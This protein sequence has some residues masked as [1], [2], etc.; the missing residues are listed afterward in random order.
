MRELAVQRTHTRAIQPDFRAR[1]V[2]LLIGNPRE[3]RRELRRLL[4]EKSEVVARAHEVADRRRN[5]VAL[6]VGRGDDA[7]LRI[8]RHERFTRARR[9]HFRRTP[10]GRNLENRAGLR[11]AFAARFHAAAI[12]DAALRDICRTIGPH[13]HVEREGPRRLALNHLVVEILEPVGLTVAVSIVK[14]HDAVFRRD[15]NHAAG[16]R[17]RER[18]LQARGKAPPFQACQ[19]LIRDAVQQPHVAVIRDNRRA[20]RREKRDVGHAHAA[21]PRVHF[22]RRN[23]VN[24]ETVLRHRAEGH[25]RGEHTGPA[26]TRRSHGPRR[27]GR[28]DRRR[29]RGG[30]E[31]DA[32]AHALGQGRRGER[33]HEFALIVAQYQRLA[34]GDDAGA[35]RI[36]FER[37]AHGPRRTARRADGDDQRRGVGRHFQI[38]QNLGLRP[39]HARLQPLADF[40]V[41]IAVAQHRGV[42]REFHALEMRATRRQCAAAN[43]ARTHRRPRIRVQRPD[44]HADSRMHGRAQ[45]RR[46][47]RLRVRRVGFSP[48]VG[49][50]DLR[51]AHERDGRLARGHFPDRRDAQQLLVKNHGVTRRERQHDAAHHKIP[52]T[53]R[54]FPLRHHFQLRLEKRLLLF[55]KRTGLGHCRR[56]GKTVWC[57]GQRNPKKEPR[58]KC[59]DGRKMFLCAEIARSQDENGAKK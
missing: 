1:G 19:F 30:V 15:L 55:E 57:K 10:V 26:Q 14:A 32:H 2:V 45:Q 47:A 8:H 41:A 6:L 52:V 39:V 29:V 54:T 12:H 11:R 58:A 37:G 18:L 4:L 48:Q 7:G 35:A 16:R 31:G 50:R 43:V 22:R 33:R 36:R 34:V 44:V 28:Q 24:H 38:P 13:R 3:R 56:Q 25:G 40:G 27:C 20:I 17:Q 53:L 5:V 49:V 21:L 46:P 42:P 51:H 59:H 23:A 9:D